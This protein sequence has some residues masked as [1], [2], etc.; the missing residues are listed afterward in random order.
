MQNTPNHPN[1]NVNV[2]VT[3]MIRVHT[4]TVQQLVSLSKGKGC[5]F[6]V[7]MGK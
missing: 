2:N 1:Y 3:Y 6:M 5:V 4:V 7:E